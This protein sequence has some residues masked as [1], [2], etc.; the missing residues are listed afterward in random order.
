MYCLT[1][2]RT[3]QWNEVNSNN[4]LYSPFSFRRLKL[5]HISFENKQGMKVIVLPFLIVFTNLPN[6]AA[7]CSELIYYNV[8]DL[9]IQKITIAVTKVKDFAV[10]GGKEVFEVPYDKE[11]FQVTAAEL[12]L[13]NGFEL[14]EHRVTTLGGRSLILYRMT[15]KHPGSIIFLMHGLFGSHEDWIL[16]GKNGLAYYLA[17]EGF[18]VWMGNARGNKYFREHDNYQ[19]HCKEF[20]HFSWDE[21]GRYDLSASIDYVLEITGRRRMIFIGH[22]QGSTTGMALLSEFTQFNSKI[23]LF[24]ALAPLTFVSNTRSP[25]LRMLSLRDNESYIMRKAIGLQEFVPNEV[26]TKS[27]SSI[28][29]DNGTITQYVCKNFMFQLCGFVVN[30]LDLPNLPLIIKRFPS[31]GSSR[32]LLHYAQELASGRFRRYDFEES[33]NINVYG[34]LFP[35]EYFL[36]NITTPVILFYSNNDWMSNNTDVEMMAEKLPQVISSNIIEGYSHLDFI[37][38]NNVKS[39]VYSKLVGLIKKYKKYWR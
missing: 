21:M 9:D 32:T 27:L 19:A 23:A 33:E 2:W 38:A 35:P 15:N 36:E 3:K 18:D 34:S 11:E 1:T 22:S 39:M 5:T 37:F 12:V 28:L 26:L 16:T 24:I 10:L 13:K 14:V 4:C 25:L 6:I 20:W 31:R 17:D 7:D 29:C 8:T 30:N